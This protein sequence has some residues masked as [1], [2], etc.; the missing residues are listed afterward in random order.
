VSDKGP[1]GA[2][3]PGWLTCLLNSRG[4]RYIP[5]LW[6]IAPLM[7]T[8]A[9]AYTIVVYITWRSEFALLVGSGA[10]LGT[11]LLLALVNLQSAT[12]QLANVRTYGDL[13]DRLR[14]LEERIA[15][16]AD[17]LESTGREKCE[18]RRRALNEARAHL[19][20]IAG[21][22]M[23]QDSR[24]VRA[25]GYNN[26]W[27]ALHSAEEALVEA[28]DPKAAASEGLHDEARLFGSDIPHSEKLLARLR[29]SILTLEPSAEKYFLD[30]VN[31]PTPESQPSQEVAQAVVRDTRS[32]I[33]QFNDS[34]YDALAR[35]RNTLLDMV[36]VGGLVAHL[37]LALAV[38]ELVPR[39]RVEA[40]VVFYLAAVLAGLLYRWYVEVKTETTVQNFG[41]VTARLFR[42][43]VFSGIAGVVG[44]LLYAAVPASLGV[45]VIPKVSVDSSP[46]PTPMAGQMAEQPPTAA[47][48][49]SSSE[50]QASACPRDSIAPL[51]CIFDLRE[52]IFGIFI[53]LLFGATPE[54]IL[55]ILRVEA[56]KYIEEVKSTSPGQ[57]KPGA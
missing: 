18:G 56:D 38:L 26:L 39:E 12:V 20:I 25:H 14:L 32:A 44:V 29:N 6:A 36:P 11:W 21:E 45:N 47:V 33:N 49:E 17:E 40:A 55:K 10:A 27:V 2:R 15:C 4:R 31:P 54:A 7:P 16:L 51:R 48:T 53:A 8:V 42:V 28:E 34:R 37:V 43:I 35:T 22:R 9:S 3:P 30:R 5:S 41:L 50:A 13:R 52:N 46:A 23:M 57:G 19:K 24:W 1:S